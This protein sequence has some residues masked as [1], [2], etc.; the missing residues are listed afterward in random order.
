MFFATEI[1]EQ[2]VLKTIEEMCPR[3]AN[4]PEYAEHFV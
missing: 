3:E 1:R 4:I 2:L